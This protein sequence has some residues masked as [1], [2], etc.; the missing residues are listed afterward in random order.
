MARAYLNDGWAWEAVRQQDTQAV[1][2][3]DAAIHEIKA[4]SY[5]DGR[6]INDHPPMEPNLGW[7]DRFQRAEDR[8]SRAQDN[9]RKVQDV[10]AAM[11]M[12]NRAL[13]HVFNAKQIVDQAWRT[14]R[15][16]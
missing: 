10:N 2:E 1:A 3:I 16:Q 15:W 5:D 8:L 6:G 13:S 14:A 11:Q 4:A 9:L 12:R 7:H